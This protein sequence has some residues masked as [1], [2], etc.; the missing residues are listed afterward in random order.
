MEKSALQDIVRV[1]IQHQQSIIGPLAL[2]RANNVKGLSADAT[3]GVNIDASVT[4]TKKL[5]QEL[6]VS[7]EELFGQTSVEVCRDAVRGIHSQVSDKD[8]PDILK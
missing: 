4:D 2:E 7:Y 6:V 5:L 1:I 3:G 8:L